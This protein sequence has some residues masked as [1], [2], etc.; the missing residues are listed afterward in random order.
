M[1]LQSKVALVTGGAQ[2]IGL[3]CATRFAEDGARVAIV[4][5]DARRGAEAVQAIGADRALFIEGDVTQTA[6]ALKA[7]D[8]TQ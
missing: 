6:T 1:K 5:L 3:A 2:G 4:D 8:A 7:I